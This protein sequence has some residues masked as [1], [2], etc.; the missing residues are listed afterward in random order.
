MTSCHSL[1]RSC[2][3]AGP[4]QRSLFLTVVFPRKHLSSFWVPNS[5]LELA[6][7]T[8]KSTSLLQPQQLLPTWMSTVSFLLSCLPPSSS[9]YIVMLFGD[10]TLFSFAFVDDTAE[11]QPAAQIG[12]YHYQEALVCKAQQSAAD[13]ITRVSPTTH[14]L[15][16]TSILP[17]TLSVCALCAA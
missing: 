11:R 14:P 3:M 6:M 4:L 15:P 1:K 12:L 13:G 10:D 5:R 8:C 7:N 17:G 2:S 16:N 9:T